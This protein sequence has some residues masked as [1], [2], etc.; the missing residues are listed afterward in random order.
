M[1]VD[2][3]YL[4]FPV[5]TLKV[6]DGKVLYIVSCADYARPRLERFLREGVVLREDAD[7]VKTVAPENSNFVS[8]LRL[9][10]KAMFGIDSETRAQDD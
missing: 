3:T 2:F 4:G 8:N 6:E 5:A 1:L 7:G 10:V 9:A